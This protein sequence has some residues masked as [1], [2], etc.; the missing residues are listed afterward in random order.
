MA[1][2]GQVKEKVPDTSF[3]IDRSSLPYHT[4]KYS[5]ITCLHN[6]FLACHRPVGLLLENASEIFPV[7]ASDHYAE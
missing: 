4:F 6:V 5:G 2:T 3:L 7:I 1:I